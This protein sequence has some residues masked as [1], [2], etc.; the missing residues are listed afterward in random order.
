[1]QRYPTQQKNNLKSHIK[2]GRYLFVL[3]TENDELQFAIN[4]SWITLNF[5]FIL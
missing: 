3:T 1:M 2:G 5:I 4:R